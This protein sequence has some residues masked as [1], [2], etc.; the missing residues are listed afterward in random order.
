M[1]E[2][3]DQEYVPEATPAKEMLLPVLDSVLLLNVTLQDTPDPRPL[4]VNV[5]V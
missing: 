1:V 5:T 3:V 4:S 2:A